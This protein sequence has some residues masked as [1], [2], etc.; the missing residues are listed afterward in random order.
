MSAIINSKKYEGAF[1]IN[2]EGVF[3]ENADGTWSEAIPL[4]YYGLRKHCS[5]G[6]KFWKEE[7]YRKHYA[8]RHTDGRSYTRTVKGLV[9]APKPQQGDK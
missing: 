5:C 6:K 7:S 2:N 8:E 4:P 9:V 3:Q 1:M